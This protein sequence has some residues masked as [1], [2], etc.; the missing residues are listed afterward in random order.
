M[1]PFVPNEYLFKHHGKEG[2]EKWEVY[3]E[4]IRDIISEVEGVPK[5]DA[6]YMEKIRYEILLGYKRDMEYKKAQ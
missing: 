2:M 5:Y 4:A 6:S 1:P 3:A